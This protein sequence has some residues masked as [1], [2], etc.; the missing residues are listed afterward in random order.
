MINP[1]RLAAIIAALTGIALSTMVVIAPNAAAAS[2]CYKDWQGDRVCIETMG[3]QVS[4]TGSDN[5]PT[6]TVYLEIVRRSDNKIVAGPVVDRRLRVA[7]PPGMYY[8][9]YSVQT[10][11]NGG[12]QVSSPTVTI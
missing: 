7:L 3:N 9:V 5:N 6:A 8:A 11:Y 4:V 12:T 2:A 1:V 10:A